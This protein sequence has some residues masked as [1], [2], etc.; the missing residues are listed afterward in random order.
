MA[1]LDDDDLFNDNV[2]CG[3]EDD[4]A[5]PDNF[6]MMLNSEV[7]IH[8]LDDEREWEDCDEDEEDEEEEEEEEE[9]DGEMVGLR[10]EVNGLHLPSFAK[11]R[12]VCWNV[13]RTSVL[14]FVGV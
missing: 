4:N 11:L 12:C 14:V 10:E 5:L 2:A 3:P 7:P 8:Q 1:G 13:W 9:E 6:V